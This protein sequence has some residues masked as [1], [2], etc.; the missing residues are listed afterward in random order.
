M[1]IQISGA[2][3]SLLKPR[4]DGQVPVVTVSDRAQAAE[5]GTAYAFTSIATANT[6]TTSTT[7]VTN[8][9]VLQN[10]SDTKLVYIDEVYWWHD[11]A[12]ACWAYL[13]IDP[14][15]GAITNNNTV[16]PNVLNAGKS[17]AADVNAYSWDEVGTV[18]VTGLSG[19]TI[20]FWQ[21]FIEKLRLPVEGRVV[22]AKNDAVSVV[23]DNETAGDVEVS[24]YMTFFV[25]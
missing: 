25:K 4:S 13:L 21:P 8:I 6:L 23:L 3:G 11:D 5:D 14:T 19:G 20:S 9:L 18:G 1:A 7:E 24:A 10:L 17:V 15:V 12:A 22:L 16:V 2:D